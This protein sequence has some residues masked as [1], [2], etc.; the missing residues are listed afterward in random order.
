[1]NNS[2]R[3]KINPLYFI[4]ERI[5]KN[6]I[7]GYINK[8]QVMIILRMH[9]NIPKDECLLWIQSLEDEGLIVKDGRYFKVKKPNKS[10]EELIIAFKKK[11]CIL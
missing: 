2:K 6:S 5:Y 11:K 1:M 10:R 3:D 4:Q 7:R 8:E 9:H